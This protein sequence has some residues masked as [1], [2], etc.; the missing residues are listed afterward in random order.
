MDKVDKIKS[1]AADLIF[2]YQETKMKA[3]LKMAGQ[4]L[5]MLINKKRNAVKIQKREVAQLL[6]Q[7]KEESARIKVEHVS[8]IFPLRGVISSLL[9]NT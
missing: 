4:R 9:D 2:G 3:H 8:F 7:K 6:A 5:N 1:S